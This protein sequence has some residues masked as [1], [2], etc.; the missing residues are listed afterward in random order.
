MKETKE[1]GEEGYTE[2]AEREYRS[3]FNGVVKSLFGAWEA[4][5]SNSDSGNKRRPVLEA[6][7]TA[8][9]GGELIWSLF[10]QW[11]RPPWQRCVRRTIVLVVIAVTAAATVTIKVEL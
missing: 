5:S 7:L 4:D 11:R 10:Y 1:S 8:Y 9:C 6:P 2:E 3:E